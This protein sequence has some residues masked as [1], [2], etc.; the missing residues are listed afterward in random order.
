MPGKQEKPNLIGKPLKELTRNLTGMGM[1]SFRG[2]QVFQ[3]IYKYRSTSFDEMTNLSRTDRSLLEKNARITR[4]TI[5]ECLRSADGTEKFLYRLEDGHTV[6]GVL[7]PETK[8]QTLCVSAQVG[9]AMN[10]RFC[11]T[12]RNGLVR[13]LTAAEIIGEVLS[14]QDRVQPRT[15]THLV[16]MGMGEP[17]ANYDAVVTALKILLDPAGCNFSNRKITLSTSGL[18]PGIRRLGREGLGINLAISL[19]ATTDTTRDHLMPVNRQYPLEPLFESLRD[20]PLPKR[21]RI[22]FEYVL[23]RGINDSS[24]DARR[25]IQLL[26]G[27]PAKINLIP[28]NAGTESNFAPPDRESMEDF[29]GILLR[30]NYTVFIRESR[31]GEIAAACGQLRERMSGHQFSIDGEPKQ[32]RP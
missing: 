19:N 17:L 25:M 2:R 29:R 5:T 32:N 14:A 6:E 7:I 28:Y 30:A 9:C 21:R 23:L 24:E 11:A 12:G 3:W 10:C 20:F 31:G 1:S 15:L 8:R 13:N 4:P 16:F 22:T 27:I 18:V 26:E